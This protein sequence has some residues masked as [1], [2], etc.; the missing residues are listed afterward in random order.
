MYKLAASIL[1]ADF[2][3][4]G[5]DVAAVLAAGADTV[6]FDVM[7]GHYVP[8]LTVGP[9]VCQ[10]LR[11]A[12][13]DAVIDVHLMVANPEQFIEPFAR[14]GA[15]MLSVHPETVGD[16]KATLQEIRSAGMQAG[17]VFNPDQVVEMDDACWKLVDMVLL[18]SVV[19]G[20][21]GQA[22]IEE[23][24][25]KINHVRGELNRRG[26]R[27]ILAV[28]GGVKVDNIARIAQAGADYFVLGSGLFGASD[29][30][31]RVGELRN[32]LSG[33]T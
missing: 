17:V 28:D 1:A 19:P 33:I 20:K 10:A 11:R 6:H 16:V 24:L 31:R 8:D 22:F 14:A 32:E 2:S 12:G 23:T 9:S 15:S 25:D 7:D 26:S 30:S 18:M 29:Y 3:R 21:G 5:V 27:A 4:L 13:V